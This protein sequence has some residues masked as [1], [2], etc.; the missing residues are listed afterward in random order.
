M[1]VNEP[2]QPSC[3]ACSSQKRGRKGQAG[4]ALRKKHSGKE[5]TGSQGAS[6]KS[7]EGFRRR[8]G[9]AQGGWR[10][11]RPVTLQRWTILETFRNLAVL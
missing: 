6:G 8:R 9:V 7:L 5:K 10:Q 3:F 1:K 2:P 4:T 11:C